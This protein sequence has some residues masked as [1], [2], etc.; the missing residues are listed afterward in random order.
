VEWPVA[1]VECNPPV[2]VS[3][4]EKV[5]LLKGN[6]AVVVLLPVGKI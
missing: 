6:L 3:V 5:G 2:G 1:S 4:D